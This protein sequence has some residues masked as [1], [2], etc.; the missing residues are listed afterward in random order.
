ML[1]YSYFHIEPTMMLHLKSPQHILDTL[2]PAGPARPQDINP[3]VVTMSWADVNASGAPERF[4]RELRGID[5][6][7]VSHVYHYSSNDIQTT[8]TI[9]PNGRGTL[10]NDIQLSGQGPRR[11]YFR[12]SFTPG[13]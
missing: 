5:W 3:E 2:I 9:N 11:E 6:A 8:S 10:I 1:Y 12:Y 13:I 4:V 7:E